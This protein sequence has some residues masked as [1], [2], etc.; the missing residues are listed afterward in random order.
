MNKSFIWKFFLLIGVLSL[1]LIWARLGLAATFG[2]VNITSGGNEKPAQAANAWN[3]N[4]LNFFVDGKK[5]GE[6]YIHV[7]NVCN[8]SASCTCDNIRETTVPGEGKGPDYSDKDLRG[9]D[10]SNKK[11]GNIRLKRSRLDGANLMNSDLGFAF[12]TQ[13]IL[14]NAV[15]KNANLAGANLQGASLKGADLEG[16]ILFDGEMLSAYPVSFTRTWK[17]VTIDTSLLPGGT[18]IEKFNIEMCAEGETNVTFLLLEGNG[19]NVK[20]ADFSGAKNLSSENIEY[21]CR[22]GGEKTRRTLGT[23]C[24]QIAQQHENPYEALITDSFEAIPQIVD[25]ITGKSGKGFSP[26]ILIKFSDPIMLKPDAIELQASD[27]RSSVKMELIRD[28]KLQLYSFL[29]TNPLAPGMSYQ[30]VLLAGK[31]IDRELNLLRCNRILGS[32]K[33]FSSANLT[34]GISEMEAILQTH[35][36]AGKEASEQGRYAEAEK[37]FAA[38]IDK[39]EKFGPINQQISGSLNN[40]GEFYMNQDRYIEAEPLLK[41]ALEVEALNLSKDP[42]K[43]ITIFN[44]LVRL[45]TMQKR[46][47]EVTS[48]SQHFPEMIENAMGTKYPELTQKLSELGMMFYK[49][50]QYKEA[51]LF[52]EKSVAIQ[53]EVFGSNHLGFALDFFHLAFIYYTQGKYDEAEPRYQK[54][55]ALQKEI[56]GEEHPN[57]AL[58]LNN[59]AKLYYKQN[60]YDQ[61][62]QLYQQSLEILEKYLSPNYLLTSHILNNIALL[63]YDQSKYT[64]A[65][66]LYKRAFQMKQDIIKSEHLKSAD[67]LKNY[68]TLLR[69]M[70]RENDALKVESIAKTIRN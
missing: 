58:I 34:N 59:L 55:V 20:D 45:Y 38:A 44:N 39:S 1:T 18:Y 61:A 68:A 10:W 29:P 52:L 26:G 17:S 70:N 40:L 5:S 65:E 37:E 42:S 14:D 2:D 63:Y 60:K 46:D 28:D 16:A 8:N 33:I 62:L 19:A 27:S 66:E 47:K 57:V 22:W 50:G 15:L 3:N 32:L 21:I 25:L 49:Q 67:I 31:A 23:K 6:F 12:L 9:K 30:I 36:L 24:D 54:S 4:I 51:G 43:I 35:M 11:L 53:K 69:K 64:E 41:H 13:S 48:L 56:F 7:V